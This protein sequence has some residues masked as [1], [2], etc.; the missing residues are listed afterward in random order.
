MLMADINISNIY[1]ELAPIQFSGVAP[2]CRRVNLKNKFITNEENRE[3]GSENLNILM[4]K[5]KSNKKKK[6]M[7]TNDEEDESVDNFNYLLDH[8]L[9]ND[10]ILG[11]YEKNSLMNSNVFIRDFCF[12]NINVLIDKPIVDVNID[13]YDNPFFVQFKKFLINLIGLDD[14][15]VNNL[16]KQFGLIN[17]NSFY[18]R[19]FSLIYT[20]IHNLQSEPHHSTLKKNIKKIPVSPELYHFNNLISL[21]VKPTKFTNKVILI[22]FIN[23]K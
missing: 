6:F 2:K 16:F 18:K 9:K 5:Q 12:S 14:H 13:F 4:K 20:T 17:F 19:F 23:N 3:V 1:N 15:I 10:D 11:F 8:S 22:N 7:V 21:K